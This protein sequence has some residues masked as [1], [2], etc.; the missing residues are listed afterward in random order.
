MATHHPR[1]HGQE[2]RTVV[3]R[4]GSACNQPEVRLVDERRGLETMADALACQAASSDAAK[5]V[6]DDG[7]RRSRAP[8]S[9]SRQSWSSAVTFV[10]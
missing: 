9:P 2:V 5:L 1:R 4:Y 3:P 10:W 6:V 8:W 7:I